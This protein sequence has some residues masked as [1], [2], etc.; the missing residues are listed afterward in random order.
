VGKGVRVLVCAEDLA[1]R[2]LRP[3]ELID[4]VETVGRGEI[5]AL[6]GGYDHVWH[7]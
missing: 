1:E 7:W 3:T 2:G 5:P 6:L 4:G